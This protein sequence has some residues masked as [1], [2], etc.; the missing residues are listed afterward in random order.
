MSYLKIRHI[1]GQWDN[2]LIVR[3]NMLV[4]NYQ[5]HPY[6]RAP[7]AKPVTGVRFSCTKNFRWHGRR[8]GGR[9]VS[10]FKIERGAYPQAGMKLW[11]VALPCGDTDAYLEFSKLDPYLQNYFPADVS[12]NLQ[13]PNFDGYTGYEVPLQGTGEPFDPGLFT[14][15]GFVGCMVRMALGIESTVVGSGAIPG[16]DVYFSYQEL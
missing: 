4:W 15:K 13:G 10:N 2:R 8:T 9:T 5:D 11:M 16:P 1:A 7:I 6:A 3:P 14:N 12:S